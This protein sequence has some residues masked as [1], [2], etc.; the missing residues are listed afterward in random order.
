MK[1]YLKAPA[2]TAN[3]GSGF[4]IF[5][6]A[7]DFFNEFYFEKNEKSEEINISTKGKYS[8]CFDP[9]PL[10]KKSMEYFF[11]LT[12]TKRIG[13][14][15]QE[16]CNIPHKRGLGSSASAI[17]ASLKMADFLSET[18]LTDKELFKIGTELEGHPDNIL[19]CFL[20]GL[21]VS[22]YYEEKLDYEKFIIDDYELSFLIPEIEMSTE[23]MRNA[24][25]DKVNFDDA[26]Y[27]LKNSLQFLS[28]ISKGKYDEAFK[29]TNDILHQKYRIK[30]NDKMKKILNQIEKNETIKYWFLSGSGSTIC[31]KSKNPALFEEENVIKKKIY[32]NPI[33]ILLIE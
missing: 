19:P 2:T 1:Y 24:L 13:I 11:K 9:N 17:A 33:K 20:G 6:I 12:G 32:N 31:F 4:D 27:N 22:Y 16:Y 5:G 23:K 14:N 8:G 10:I 28:K 25:P 15:I 21:V 7:L 18:N 3:I 26:I 29:Y 30:T